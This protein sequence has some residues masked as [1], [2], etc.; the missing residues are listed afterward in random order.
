MQ[1]GRRAAMVGLA[2]TVDIP[3]SPRTGGKIA[4]AGPIGFVVSTADG[5]GG[6]SWKSRSARTLLL[7]SMS[8]ASEIHVAF[9]F[10]RD[11]NQLMVLQSI[12][13]L[14]SPLEGQAIG[15]NVVG[16]ELNRL[17]QISLPLGKRFSRRAE[18]QIE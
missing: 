3:G 5:Q 17:L 9:E 2:N 18:D 13:K 1:I 14:R 11:G 15:G 7:V 4:L 10:F 12:P 8:M 16:F 6:R